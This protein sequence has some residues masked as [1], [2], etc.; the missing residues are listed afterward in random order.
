MGTEEGKREVKI[1]TTL[2]PT[3][4]K[5]LIDLLQEYGDVFVWSYQDM[6]G[7]N[8]DIMVHRLSLREECMSVKQKLRR[9]KPEML[10]KIKDE[11][12]K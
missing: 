2:S 10:L 6:S 1:R 5:D 9:V 11:V 12:K 4:R 3:T 8:I 7:L